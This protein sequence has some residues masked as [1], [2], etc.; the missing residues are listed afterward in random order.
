MRN[1]T[2]VTLSLLSAC[3]FRV[4]RGIPVHG[5]LTVNANVNVRAQGA[6]RVDTVVVPLQN[7]PV[8]EFFGIPLADASDVLFVLDVSG[9]MSERAEGQIAML[10]PPPTGAQPPPPIAPPPGAP[11][12][13]A[14]P[15]NE[16]APPGAQPPP[17]A[18]PPPSA[19]QPMGYPPGYP[20]PSSVPPA[21]EAPPPAQVGMTVPTKLEVAQSELIDAVAKLPAGTRV[22]ILIFSND[23][24]AYAPNMVVI[25]ET[26][27]S[28]LIAF[29][30]E[31]QATGAT[32][33][34]PAMRVSFLLNARRIVLLSDGLGN[35]GG[36]RDDI[37]RDVREAARAPL[38]IDAI[39]I[40]RGQDTRLL[41]ELAAETG[42]L[43]QAL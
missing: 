41:S 26:S 6:A 15:S 28:E 32:A 13:A 16:P 3:S 39:G 40:G 2:L 18:A 31:M 5:K 24:D 27:R 22:N 42:G 1:R 23:V 11:P 43:Y 7:A 38:R 9:S 30:R 35:I 19:P 20:P 37:M 17:P 14:P 12:P 36:G 4:P 34:Q 10:P 8:V 25:D 29:V 21:A 33:L